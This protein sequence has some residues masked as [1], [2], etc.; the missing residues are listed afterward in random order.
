MISHPSSGMF[1][2]GCVCCSLH[3]YVTEVQCD[4]LCKCV[5]SC[6]LEHMQIHCSTATVE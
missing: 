3:E 4:G 1:H 2:Y 5:T 6:T